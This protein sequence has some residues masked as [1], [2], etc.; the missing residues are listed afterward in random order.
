[1]SI[2]AAI[3]A[4]AL[5]VDH[6]AVRTFQRR[7]FP[8]ACSTILPP[9]GG[10]IDVP[11]RPRLAAYAAIARRAPTRAAT[12]AALLLAL[13]AATAPA[14]APPLTATLGTSDTQIAIQGGEAAPRLIGLTAAGTTWTNRGS[15]ALPARLDSGGK[16][17]ALGWH[18]DRAAS[19]VT[20][21]E[22]RLVYACP[23]PRLNL[24]WEWHA[25]AD[26]GPIEHTV[27]LENLSHESVWLPLQSSL[28]FDWA[29]DQNADLERFWV[30]KG[31]DTPSARGTH[32]DALRE[33]ERWQGTSSTYARPIAGTAREMIPFVLVEGAGGERRGWYLGIEFSG[34]TQIALQRNGTSLRGEAGLNPAP[35]PYR[36]RLAPGATFS[37]PTVFIGASS[38]GPDQAG[39]VLRRWVRRVLNSPATLADPSYPLL[40]SNSWG[41][42]MA[43]DDAAARRMISDARQLGLEM[44]HLDAGWFRGVGDWRADPSKFPQGIGSIADFAHASGLRFGLWVDWTQAGNS[45]HPGALTILDPATRDW[46]ISDPP[47]GWRA[48]EP[49][50]GITIDLGVP[51]ARAWAAKELERIVDSYRLDMLEHDGYLVAQGSARAD[52]P[53]VPPEP[54]TLHIYEDS[55]YVWVDG[56]NSTDVSYHATRAYYEIYQRLRAHHPQLLLEVCNDGGRMVDFGSAAHGDYFSITDSYD[57]LSNRRAFFDASYVLPPAMLEAYV[58]QWRAPSLENLRYMLRSGMLGWFSLMLDT[59][60][61]NA[62]ERADAR[63]QFALYKSALRPLIRTADLY[64]VSDRPDGVHWDGIEY[65]SPELARGVLYAFRGSTP[66]EHSHRF[67]L[68][69]VASGSRY[70]L[71]FH[72]QGRRE[73]ASGAALMR[74]GVTVSLASPLSSELVFFERV[75][76]PLGQPGPAPASRL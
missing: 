62:S 6:R 55:G 54:A 66:A 3:R 64:H 51:A 1:M 9:L 41:S 27:T 71:E 23:S 53:A 45:S 59:S 68:S 33:D 11:A 25:R 26:F 29:I 58:A 74:D 49:F 24:T 44:F 63:A 36:T 67:R 75:P 76:E 32:L 10:H 15:V 37:T 69:G 8:R 40:V 22:V 38:G 13:R 30:E 70:A 56:S 2:S 14:D 57:P 18:L 60:R 42:G 50:K 35:G 52:H 73:I 12:A 17:T 46:L 5:H 28:S 21:A 19:R 4:F 16:A 65:Y 47:A 72:D 7:L 48:R 34:R 61:W 43:V 39:N 20:T 31:A